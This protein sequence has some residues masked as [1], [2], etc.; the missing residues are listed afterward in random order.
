MARYLRYFFEHVAESRRR[1]YAADTHRRQQAL[2][3]EE[4]ASVSA[5]DRETEAMFGAEQH[6]CVP[7]DASDEFLNEQ[8]PAIKAS[9]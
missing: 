6:W 5:L 8:L 3:G 1:E 9:Q 7:A 4:N 2:T